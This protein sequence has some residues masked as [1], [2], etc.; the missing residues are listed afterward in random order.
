MTVL[1]Q[2]LVLPTDEFPQLPLDPGFAKLVQ[3]E[4][5]NVVTPTDGFDD[6]VAEA[7]AIVDGVDSALDALGGGLL[8]A[9][10]EADL[11]DAK[12]V[13]D[14]VAGFTA[15]LG[16]TSSAVDDLGTL[17]ATVAPPTPT[18]GGGG[19]GP[20]PTG[21]DIGPTSPCDECIE[22]SAAAA[23][24]PAATYQLSYQNQTNGPMTVS[25]VTLQQGTP[26]VFSV[27]ASLPA[28]IPVNGSLPIGIT[29]AA[30]QSNTFHA[31]VT[32]KSTQGTGTT[33]ACVKVP[34]LPA[35]STVPAPSAQFCG[36]GT[37]GGGGTKIKPE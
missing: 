33:V 29:V 20:Q 13:S 27:K 1:I 14:T 11:I 17:L 6:V 36:G 5:G 22:L 25:S 8:D 30:S 26:A 24:A 7:I 15:S 32:I 34:V 4:L 9:F 10:A 21:G 28:V 18:G 19:G 16:P 37:G 2:P 31:L 3:D 23:G 35:G 12:P